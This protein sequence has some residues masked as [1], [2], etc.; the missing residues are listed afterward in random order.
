MSSNN[1]KKKVHTFNIKDGATAVEILEVMKAGGNFLRE[2]P[3]GTSVIL[4]F[5]SD[6]KTFMVARNQESEEERTRMAV[7]SQI[8]GTPSGKGKDAIV[9]TAVPKKE[10]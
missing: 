5:E 8:Y 3:K 4:N 6:G 9:K 10:K 2:S 7:L 1:G